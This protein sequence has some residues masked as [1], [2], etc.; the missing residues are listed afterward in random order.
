[1]W[2]LTS[3]LLALGVLAHGASPVRQRA[4]EPDPADLDRRVDAIARAALETDDAEG[5]SIAID[6]GGEHVLAGGWGLAPSLE[7]EEAAADSAYRAGALIVPF[8]AT[9]VLRLADE[10]LV[11]PDASV[12]EYLEDLPFEPGQI[13]VRMLLA[14]TSGIPAYPDLRGTTD[15]FDAPVERAVLLAWMAE[16]PLDAEPGT[17]LAHSN[18]NTLLLG[19]ILERV[20][21]KTVRAYLEE[22]FFERLGME[23]TRF[24]WDG[25]VLRE[26]DEGAQEFAGRMVDELGVPLPFEATGLCTSAPDLVRWQRALLDGTLLE[27]AGLRLLTT[28]ALEAPEEAGYGH[29]VGL[30]LL[31]VHLAYTLGGTTSGCATHL[32]HYP[33][34]DLTVAV[35]ANGEDADVRAVE[36]RIARAFFGLREPGIHDLALPAAERAAFLGTFYVGC[37]VYEILEAGEGLAIMEPGERP[38]ALLFQGDRLFLVQDELGIR[39]TF[40]LDESGRARAF[41]YDEYGITSR[42]VRLE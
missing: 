42:A 28:P 30:T 25:P 34:L 18:T 38:R 10:G 35:L 40:E 22:E 24:C 13:T 32:A 16:Q 12:T 21:E 19:W 5:L 37:F 15:D 7:R 31:D 14:E 41:E 17:C 9:A 36:R 23:E 27:S 39:L 6:I 3:T 29:G 4:Q 11:D 33:D 8:V 26:L 1:M 2:K 20:T